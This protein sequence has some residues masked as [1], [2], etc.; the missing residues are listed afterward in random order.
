M[1]AHLIWLTD[2]SEHAARCI[3]PL[4]ALARALRADVS[5]VHALGGLAHMEAK[6]TPQVWDLAAR[7]TEQGMTA[8]P[9]ISRSQPEQL[10]ASWDRP[11]QLVIIGRTGTS[12]LERVLLGS[13]TRAVIDAS[14]ADVLVV[15]GRP[16]DRLQR[17]LCP[18]D[19][20]PE[21]P[22]A[23]AP[24]A[25]LA[26]SLGA[27]LSFL[28]VQDI[29]DATPPEEHLDAL[30]DLVNERAAPA[31][32]EALDARFEVGRGATPEQ[33][34]AAVADQYELIVM[35]SRRR[36]ALARFVLGSVTDHLIH[37]SPV[38]V[39]VARAR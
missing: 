11:D 36:S 22:D 9:V 28:Y 33:A 12:G 37:H 19:L 39:L 31:L 29:D 25:K 17:L 14:A 15:G 7:L 24:A 13:T 21:A 26:V 27:R 30:R 20:D 6:I 10:A 4:R 32:R 34:I 16:F 2:L 38:P 18:V 1:Y 35:A 3:K 8:H 23:I 5:V